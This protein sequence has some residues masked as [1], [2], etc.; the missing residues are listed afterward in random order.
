MQTRQ[1]RARAVATAAA[2]AVLT[3]PTACSS[4]PGEDEKSATSVSVAVLPPI[5]QPGG[6]PAAADDASVV[7]S[8][9]FDPPSP[10]RDVTL[11]GSKDGR[12]VEVA[13]AEVGGNGAATFAVPAAGESAVASYRVVADEAYGLA[14]VTSGEVDSD[15]WGAAAF[16]DE[17]DGTGLSK[18][19]YH[20]GTEYNPEGLRLCSR[21]SAD[22]VD[23]GGGVL[24]VQVIADPARTDPC[25]ARKADG[26]PLG[27]FDY[28][29]NGHIATKKFF[30]YGVSAARIKFQRQAGQHG[31]LW[32]QSDVGLE[33]DIVEYF[34]DGRDDKDD[35]LASFVYYPTPEGFV[36][37]GDFIEDAG[38]YLADKSDDWWKRYH[39][40]ALERTAEEYVIRIDGQEAWRTDQGVSGHPEFIILSLLSSDYELPNLPDEELLPQ[41]M[42]VDWVRHWDS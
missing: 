31:S 2:L 40:F 20:R 1:P 27:E 12:W 32:M 4:A 26:T 30:L 8:A 41:V 18:A 3:A 5:S 10:G 35:R 28:R 25:V 6:R 37:E 14:A 19:W 15:V 9:R 24:S 38:D 7:V 22:A 17:F 39:V 16:D 33:I 13:T 36:K 29:L 11:E 42:D 34:G 23:V 21:G